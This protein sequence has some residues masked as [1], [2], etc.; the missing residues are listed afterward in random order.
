LGIESGNLYDKD[1][2]KGFLV[3]SGGDIYCGVISKQ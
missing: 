1:D 3:S 2:S